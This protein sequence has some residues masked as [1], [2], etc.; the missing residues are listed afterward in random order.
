MEPGFGRTIPDSGSGGLQVGVSIFGHLRLEQ[1]LER[2]EQWVLYLADDQQRRELVLVVFAISGEALTKCLAGPATG[3]VLDRTMFG[4]WHMA[5]VALEE[6]H[7]E[8]FAR[9]ILAAPL[10]SASSSASSASEPPES[11]TLSSPISSANRQL[12]NGNVFAA[13]YRIEDVL[14]RGGMGEVYRAFDTTFERGVAL[15]VVR[16]DA[17]G[18]TEQRDQAKQRLLGEARMVSTLRHPHIAEIYDAAES[19]GLPYLVLELCD[20]GNLRKAMSENASQAERLRWLTEIA[21]ALAYAHDHG[22]VHRDVKPENVILTRDRAAKVADFGIAKALAWTGTDTAGIVGTPRYMAPEQLLGGTVDARADQFAWGVLAYEVLTGAHPR[23]T[24]VERLSQRSSPQ[25]MPGVPAHVARVIRRAMSVEKTARYPDFHRL[26]AALRA[27]GASVLSR[28]KRGVLLGALAAILIG[29]TVILSGA[30]RRPPVTPREP[31]ET[32]ALV[33]Q[34]IQLWSDGSSSAAR[35]RFAEAAAR[36]PNDV[37]AHLLS[38]A[39]AKRIDAVAR[40]NARVALTFHGRLTE[41]DGL[42]LEALR[43]LV[44]EPTD[45]TGSTQRLEELAQRYP[46]NKVVRLAQAQHYIRAREPR[47]ALELAAALDTTLAPAARWLGAAAQLQLGNVGDGRAMLEDCIAI[48]PNATDCLDWLAH[49]EAND[50][51]CDAAERATRKLI[52]KNPDEPM[53]YA[54]LANIVLAQTQSTAATRGILETRIERSAPDTRKELEALLALFLHVFDGE[55]DAA[56][57]DVDAWQS[58]GTSSDAML[59]SMPFLWRLEI[60]RE[61]GLDEDARRAA[62]EVA[63]RS[64]AWLPNDIYD[65]GIENLRALYL[66]SQISRSD[67]R[68]ARDAAAAKQLERGGYFSAPGVR[69]FENYVRP[70]RDAVD[71]EDA[72]AARP[73][74]S[75]IDLVERD[76]GVDSS[77]GF[78]Y[79]RAGRIHEAITLLRRATSACSTLP[80][81]QDYV[82]ALLWL[83]E[84]LDAKG[85]HAEACSAYS[86]VVERWGREPRSITARRARAKLSSCP[87]EVSTT[88]EP[89]GV[90]IASEGP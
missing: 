4:V 74:D 75:V 44:D 24:G 48:S 35:T 3:T 19:S 7:L 36:D 83:G 56:L 50:G 12:A 60:A 26:L 29:Y 30:A 8:A 34:G 86:K 71:A 84:S 43:P 40:S 31:A 16:V 63:Y 45:V 25:D 38:F 17:E 70:A 65:A 90:Q 27:G 79:L 55:F 80:K 14:G 10:P 20:G 54:L 69:W 61:L 68:R 66:T 62:R 52:A 58:A 67:F 21:E 15:K 23:S 85:Q 87:K 57:R 9:R 33:E 73:A 5:E 2:G 81:P 46:S 18:T 82:H 88:P 64:N 47:R 6:A 42:L 11:A 53:A 13:R 41:P 37:R 77:L 28:T 72:I 59:R 51:R 39:A 22:I 49:L 76:A 78:V 1:L 32:T 89:S